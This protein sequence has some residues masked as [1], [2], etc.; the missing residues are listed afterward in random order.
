VRG[1]AERD[2]LIWG[3]LRLALGMAQIVLSTAALVLLS[4]VG[5]RS[6]TWVFILGAAIAMVVSRLLYHGRSGP[7]LKGE[8]GND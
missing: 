7:G 3:W 6:I 5:L 1:P 2:K 8:N 4:A